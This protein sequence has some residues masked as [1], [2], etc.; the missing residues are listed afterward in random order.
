MTL[1]KITLLILFFIL[2]LFGL[3]YLILLNNVLL[4][5]LS[6]SIKEDNN[7]VLLLFLISFKLSLFS[8]VLLI[9]FSFVKYNFFF[10]YFFMKSLLKISSILYLFFAFLS[11]KWHIKSLHSLLIFISKCKS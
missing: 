11:S 5:R 1:L 6:F 7:N 4:S 10:S 3:L 9:Y 8:F 2:Y